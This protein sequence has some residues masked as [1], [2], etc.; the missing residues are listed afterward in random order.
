MSDFASAAM[1][2][3]IERG[4]ALQGLP[5]MLPSAPRGALIDLHAKR[6]LAAALWQRHGPDVLV[7][8]GAAAHDATREPLMAALTPAQDARDLLWRWQRLER[9]I[10]SRHRVQIDDAQ[11]GQVRL[12]HVSLAAG[13]LPLPAEDLLVF[14]LLIALL[15]RTGC[16]GLTARL[17]GERAWRYAAGRWI[18]RRW[19]ADLSH[20]EL[21]WQAQQAQQAQQAPLP[22]SRQPAPNGLERARERLAADPSREWRVATLAEVLHS[23]VRSLQRQLAAA[24]TPFS[25]LLSEVRA[26]HAGHLLLSTASST[27]EVGYL[28]GYA[29]QAHFTR[30]FKRHVALTPGQ[31]RKEFTPRPR[32]SHRATALPATSD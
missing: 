11:P 17:A 26:T 6:A 7:R 16:G 10:H 12:R 27:A 22:S 5:P 4:L 31:F 14:G 28:S 30:E 29:D 32:E 8:I 19:P 13:R 18:E 15:E 25:A 3:L 24:G 23:S 2:R 9:F 1:L 21:R 20:W